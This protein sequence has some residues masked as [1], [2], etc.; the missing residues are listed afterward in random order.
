MSK[1]EIDKVKNTSKMKNGGIWGTWEIEMIKKSVVRRGCKLMF[2]EAIAGINEVDDR[3]FDLK[4]EKATVKMA[5]TEPMPETVVPEIEHENQED[6]QEEPHIEDAPIDPPQDVQTQ[7][8]SDDILFIKAKIKTCFPK[9]GKK[10]YSFSI[11]GFDGFMSTFDK[12][13]AA[14]MERIHAD[15]SEAKISYTTEVKGKFTN[16]TITNVD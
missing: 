3:F 10:P 8:P 13:I 4:R 1:K 14:E 12:Y 6:N 11:E 5:K 9:D 15:K 7:E 2:A 16:N